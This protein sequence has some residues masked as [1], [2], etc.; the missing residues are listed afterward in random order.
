VPPYRLD[1]TATVLRRLSTNMIDIFGPDRV[2]RRAMHL[3]GEPVVIEVDQPAEDELRLIVHGR[4]P[5]RAAAPAL[6][7][8]MLG[9][10]TDVRS[11]VRASREVA[12]L[13]PLVRRMRG[14]RPPR[15]PTLWEACVNAVVFQQISIHAA[16]AILGRLIAAL[17]PAVVWRGASLY[18]FPDASTYA[19]A[20]PR[21]LRDVGLSASKV[22]TLLG[23]AD[24]LATGTLDETQLERLPT[25]E[26]LTA[27]SA[28]KGIGQWTA[29]I[30]LLRGMGRFDLFP[31]NDSGA[32]R[33]FALLN[34]GKPVATVDVLERLGAQRGMLYYHLL[35][36][37]LEARGEL[38]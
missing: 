7:E 34:A 18:A 1:L 26:A 16:G 10:R 3:A 28:H 14:V 9:T 13:A 5:A 33:S 29:A 12:W 27:L 2:Y 21:V 6:V 32:A 4:A 15:Y 25:P 8:R 30:I 19:A 11:F 24:A 31:K 23:L 20:E 37:R 22:S 38:P 35:L 36:A 17:A